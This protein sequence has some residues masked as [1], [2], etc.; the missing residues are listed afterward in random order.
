[1]SKLSPLMEGLKKNQRSQIREGWE[2]DMVAE[3]ADGPGHPE[4]QRLS[5]FLECLGCL[6][7][8]VLSRLVKDL[9]YIKSITLAV[10]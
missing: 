7:G 8:S 1:M 5:F 10:F 6:A 9:V 2:G 4:P 3:A